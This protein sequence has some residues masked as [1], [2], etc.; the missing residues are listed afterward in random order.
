LVEAAQANLKIWRKSHPR[1]SISVIHAS[2]EDAQLPGGD[3]FVFLNNPFVGKVLETVAQKLGELARDDRR[4][5]VAFSG[6][7]HADV[8]VRDGA[9]RRER[10]TPIR[11]WLKASMS[12]FRSASAECK[13]AGQPVINL[14]LNRRA[15]LEKHCD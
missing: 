14:L 13:N 9:F 2:A 3:L 4:I 1:T 11:P 5:V 6:D 10:L 8:F 15:Q 7:R 12:I